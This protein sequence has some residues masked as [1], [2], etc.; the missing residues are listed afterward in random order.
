MPL[1][2]PLLLDPNR[3]V[4]WAADLVRALEIT[5][6]SFERTKQ[7]RGAIVQLPSYAKADLPSPSPAGQKLYVTDDVGGAT[8]A[9]SDDL[10]WRRSYDRVQ[11]S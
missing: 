8:E 5:L 3:L 2:L 9:Y 11:V 10:V 6:T 4:V 7:T 1:R